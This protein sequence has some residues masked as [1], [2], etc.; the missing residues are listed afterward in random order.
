MRQ[1]AAFGAVVV[2]VLWIY[3]SALVFLVG[4]C[5]TEALRRQ[6]DA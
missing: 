4:C 2:L 5:V 6:Q 1:T 3:Y